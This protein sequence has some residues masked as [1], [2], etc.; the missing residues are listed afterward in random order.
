LIISD[1]DANKPRALNVILFFKWK[2][3]SRGWTSWR[4][5]LSP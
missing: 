3:L 2:Q 5:F 4:S 1:F